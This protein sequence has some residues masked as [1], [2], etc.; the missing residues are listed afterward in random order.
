MRRLAWD[1]NARIAEVRDRIWSYLT[2]ASRFEMPGLLVAAA[3]LKWP[4]ADA[5]RL[6]DL[7]FLLSDEVGGLLQEMPRLVRRLATASARDEELTAERLHG[8]VDWNAT[9]ALRASAGSRYVGPPRV[10]WR[11]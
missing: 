7:Q 6:A 8:P 9:L 1:R 4:E 5:L 10:S 2:P 3:L 11:L